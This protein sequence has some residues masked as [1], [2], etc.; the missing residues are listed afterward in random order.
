M[1]PVVEIFLAYLAKEGYNELAC[2]GTGGG[3][4]PPVIRFYKTYERGTS[5]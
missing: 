2:D 5:P 4:D 1:H 3:A